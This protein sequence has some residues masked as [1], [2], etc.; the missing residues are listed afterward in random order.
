LLEPFGW[1]IHQMSRSAGP[2]LVALVDVVRR[3]FYDA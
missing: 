2:I 1:F 3:W